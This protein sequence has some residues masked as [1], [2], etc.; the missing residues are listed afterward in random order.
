[1][2]IRTGVAVGL[3]W[4]IT[5]VG[6]ALW[7]QG[8]TIIEGPQL[9]PPKRIILSGDDIGFQAT[10]PVQQRPGNGAKYVR[11][12]LMVRIDGEWIY[13]EVAAGHYP[14]ELGREPRP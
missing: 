4:A 8:G 5:L 12:A 3:V 9:Q 2:T 14:W 13:A 1:M 10:L 6:V 11:G 7:A